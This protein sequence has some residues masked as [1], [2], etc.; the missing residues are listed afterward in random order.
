[1]TLTS[2]AVSEPS[3]DVLLTKIENIEKT[4]TEIKSYLDSNTKDLNDKFE[5]QRVDNVELRACYIELKAKVDLIDWAVK[6]IL[7]GA[8]GGGAVYGGKIVSQRKHNKI[9]V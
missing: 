4:V 3:G 2:Q 9:G 5:S 1:M 6:I 7:G 8:L